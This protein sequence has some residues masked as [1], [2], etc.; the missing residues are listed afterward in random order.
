MDYKRNYTVVKVKREPNTQD[1][2]DIQDTHDTQDTQTQDKSDIRITVQ[3]TD[4]RIVIT[5]KDPSQKRR[6]MLMDELSMRKLD[7][8][9]GGVCDSFIK[10]GRPSL[11]EV[12]EMCI[13]STMQEE[14]RLTILISNL[15]QNDLIYDDRVSYYKEY[16]EQGTDLRTAITEGKKEWFYINMTEYPAFLAKYKDEERAMARALDKYIKQHGYDSA[17]YKYLDSNTFIMS[18]MKI[19]LY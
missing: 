9:R 11:D 12:I 8:V 1:T 7:Y 14:K 18:N 3:Q 13:R 16:I 17:I 6:Q 2:Y 19:R 10:Y 4:K 15:K 5:K